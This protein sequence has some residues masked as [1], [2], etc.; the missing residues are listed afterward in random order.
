MTSLQQALS[1]AG[2]QT[3]EGRLREIAMQ[4]LYAHPRDPY[5]RRRAIMAGIGDSAPL[6]RLLFER[7]VAD[8]TDRLVAAVRNDMLINQ[9]TGRAQAETQWPHVRAAA[10]DSGGHARSEAHRHI[11]PA[12]D[13]AVGDR[14]ELEARKARVP[15]VG[16]QTGD[17]ESFE[18][19][20]TVVPGAGARA[21]AAVTSLSLL[22]TFRVNGQA[23]G[24]VSPAEARLWAEARGRQARRD[25]R[26][27][28]LITAG[29]PDGLPI[30]RYRRDDEAQAAWAMALT[31]VA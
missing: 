19:Q 24:D 28:E 2:Y 10:L 12:A 26:F 27:I 23:L 15:G 4:A 31:E 3:S 16:A 9:R 18:A 14:H 25:M 22:D 1:D 29:L 21:I 30:R 8:A 6:L 17:R 20:S 11:A 5:A 13:A 7:Y